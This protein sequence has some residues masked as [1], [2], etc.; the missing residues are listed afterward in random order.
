MLK[1]KVV[2]ID[3]NFASI[4]FKALFYTDEVDIT[5]EENKASAF[6]KSRRKLI[7]SRKLNP[8]ASE[9]YY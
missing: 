6:F 9:N 5:F 3:F 1:K 8:N 7:T 2:S 4:T